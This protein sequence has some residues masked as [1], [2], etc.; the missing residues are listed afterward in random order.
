LNGITISLADEAADGDY[1]GA[2]HKAHYSSQTAAPAVMC[3]MR[4]CPRRAAS[5]RQSPVAGNAAVPRSGAALIQYSSIRQ[6]GCPW[7]MS[8]GDLVK[9]LV[10]FVGV[11]LAGGRV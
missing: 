9:S 10:A 11:G 5:K 1:N 2:C 3:Y 8:A 4:A 7:V 6:R